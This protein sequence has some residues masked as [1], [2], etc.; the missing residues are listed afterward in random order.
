MVEGENVWFGFPHVSTLLVLAFF[1]FI[2]IFI[3]KKCLD[4]KKR[5][6]VGIFLGILMIIIELGDLS[7]RLLFIGQSVSD[8]LPFHLC[9]PIYYMVAV[10]LITRNRTLYDLTYFLGIAGASNSLLTPG[11]IFPFPHFLNLTFFFTHGMIIIGILWMT[12][13][14]KGYRPTWKAYFKTFIFL[15]VL[16]VIVIPVN[17]LFNTNY[18]FICYKPPG[19]TIMDLLGPWPVYLIFVEL[20][21]LI[22]CLIAFSPFIIMDIVK[23][24]K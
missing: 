17:L 10:M 14:L 13:S 11:E 5:K 15:N 12:I 20:L 3:S 4:E 8:N 2:L 21:G 22:L 7:Y 24:S 19:G 6:G 1:G 18:L 16:G 23:A 9:G